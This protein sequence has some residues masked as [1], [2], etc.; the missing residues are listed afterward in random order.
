MRTSFFLMVLVSVFLGGT[1]I[2][3]D[4]DRF[5][6][7]DMRMWKKVP[8]VVGRPV[9]QKDIDE[10]RA[11]FRIDGPQGA[12]KPIDLGLPRCAIWHDQKTQ[13]DVPVIIIQAE[14]AG[15]V[16]AAGIRFLSGGNAAC[17]VS[18]LTLLDGPDE[19]FQTKPPKTG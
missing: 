13:K 15:G 7:I 6:P 5:G 19:R 12:V 4:S 18:E 9:T 8:C 17:L 2:G 10:G 1:L 11:V 3:K 14:E 16:R